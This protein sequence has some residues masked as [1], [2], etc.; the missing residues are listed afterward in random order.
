MQADT[1]HWVQ[2]QG[3]DPS[4]L[5]KQGARLLVVQ[6]VELKDLAMVHH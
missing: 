2:E 3:G 6:G 5:F 1:L 4:V